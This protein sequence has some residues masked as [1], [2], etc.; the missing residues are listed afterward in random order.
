MK[1][2]VLLFGLTLLW[3][4]WNS[5]VYSQEMSIE[6]TTDLVEIGS[7]K[8]N[9]AVYTDEAL[10]AAKSGLKQGQKIKIPGIATSQAIRKLMN[11]R[12]FSDVKIE[13]QKRI[14]EFVFLVIEVKEL[15]LLEK[16]VIE[17][18]TKKRYQRELTEILDLLIPKNTSVTENLQN[19]AELK[20]LE[21]FEEQG[22]PNAEVEFTQTI[23]STENNK[24]DLV[25]K[26]NPNSSVRTTRITFSGNDNVSSAALRKQIKE[27]KTNQLFGKSEFIESAF[28]QDKKSI[29]E[30]YRSQGYRDAVISNVKKVT[31]KEGQLFVLIEIEEGDVYYFGNITFHGNTVYPSEL[32]QTVLEI[33]KGDIFNESLLQERLL[34]SMDGSDIS[35]LY[36]DNGFLF[37]QLKQKEIGLSENT[38][39]L[40]IHISEGGKAYVGKVIISGNEKTSEDVIRREIRTRPGDEFSRAAIIRTQRQ[41]ANMG[42][43]NPQTL[44]IK[45]EI[46]QESGTV[47][48][49]YI[50]EEKPN[51]QL[52]LSAGWQPNADGDG[53]GVVGTVGVSFNNFSFKNLFN[54]EMPFGD[55][56]QIGI[57]AQSSGKTYQSLNLS[58]TE[59]W[60]G[61]KKPQNLSFGAYVTRYA[62]STTNELGEIPY[63]R[64]AGGKVSF[65]SRLD[66]IDDYLVST[67]N[68]TYENIDLLDFTEINQEDGTVISQGNFNNLY[69]KQTFS[70]NT[71]D[72]PFFPRRGSILEFSGQFTAPYSL[73]SKNASDNWLEYHKWRISG[74]FYLP[75]SK[76]LVF[77]GAIKGGYL[78]RYNQ[79]KSRSV[80]ER[81]DLDGDALQGQESNITG[82]DFV[83]FRGYD[84]SELPAVANGG[85]AI[86]N[87]FTAELRYSLFETSAS[88]AYGILFAEAGNAWDDFGS[89]NPLDL[90]R[91]AGIGVRV[92]VPMIGVL[93]FDYSLGFDSEYF[94]KS[95]WYKSGKFSVILGFD[96]N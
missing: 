53:G 10:V 77:K 85:A 52:E 6:N 92:Q 33:N 60:L 56:Q 42:Y 36:L 45:T 18:L 91:S 96:P 76:K 34:M 80:F 61:G 59:P 57:R 89:Y 62:S 50:V 75:L 84:R 95:N 79:D 11:T 48:I 63:L 8:V 74:D 65:S 5:Y 2:I 67:T 13:E 21:Y 64:I 7:V 30:Y 17:G 90:K 81:F 22:L 83:Y 23:N 27:T 1:K 40:E 87:K 41:L 31:D 73:L 24:I 44:D 66:G 3:S 69:L 15:P 72:A 4:A 25:C 58:F 43:F 37:F 93:G 19:T 49:E 47:D 68:L 38:V 55:G 35:S 9:G 12:L 94:D 70:R 54:G 16:I 14:G 88:S 39:D 46:N 20:I 71:T 29:L 82:N 26:I 28:E 86:F 32:L 51:D 78:G